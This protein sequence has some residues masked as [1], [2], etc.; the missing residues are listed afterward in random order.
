M[1]S[2]AVCQCQRARINRREEHMGPLAAA[3]CH[4]FVLGPL[5]VVVGLLLLDVE[6]GPLLLFFPSGILTLAEYHRQTFA[7]SQGGFT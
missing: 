6:I 4:S 3:V 1:E 5:L 7:V 2:E